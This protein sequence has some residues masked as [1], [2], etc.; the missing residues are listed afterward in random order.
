MTSYPSSTCATDGSAKESPPLPAVQSLARDTSVSSTSTPP[1][2]SSAAQA[3]QVQRINAYLNNPIDS[4]P[5]YQYATTAA[6]MAASAKDVKAY[7]DAFDEKMNRT[8]G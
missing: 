4:Q 8:K 1:T 2:S 5:H 6:S 3:L 7:L